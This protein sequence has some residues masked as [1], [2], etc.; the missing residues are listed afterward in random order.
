[1]FERDNWTCVAPRLDPA[2]GPCYNKWGET[3]SGTDLTGGHLE[4]DRIRDDAS[5]GAAPSHQ[6]PTRMVC[7][8]PGHHRGVG[9]QGGR[10]WA[11]AHRDLLRDYLAR[12]GH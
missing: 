4:A 6:D 9:P 10:Q 7:L 8:C 5:M 11:T 2:A 1:M 12:F 3:F